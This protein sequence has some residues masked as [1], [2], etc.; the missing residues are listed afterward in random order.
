MF[1]LSPGGKKTKIIKTKPQT[2]TKTNKETKMEPHMVKG[3]GLWGD[4]T[5]SGGSLCSGC[6]HQA[7]VLQ[8]RRKGAEKCP[9]KHHVEATGKS[10]MRSE[11]TE[12]V[13]ILRTTQETGVGGSGVQG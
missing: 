11:V 10:S 7:S 9:V 6:S 2:L 3:R 8:E 12:S 1:A 5:F 4:P 13:E